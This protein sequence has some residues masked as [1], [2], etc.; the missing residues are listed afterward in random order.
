MAN[1]SG[2]FVSSPRD[3]LGRNVL[4]LTESAIDCYRDAHAAREAGDD[5]TADALCATADR[6]AAAVAET[7]EALATG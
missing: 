3:Q 1:H 2:F 4:R 7:L 5:A 6:A